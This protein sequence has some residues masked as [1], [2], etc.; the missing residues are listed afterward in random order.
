MNV[1]IAKM[2]VPDPCTAIVPFNHGQSTAAKPKLSHIN[3][4]R[5]KK[6]PCKLWHLRGQNSLVAS[7]EFVC[8]EQNSSQCLERKRRT[9]YTRTEQ[10]CTKFGGL[11]SKYIQLPC[12]SPSLAYFFPVFV[13][14]VFYFLVSLP[15]QRMWAFILEQ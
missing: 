5:W 8:W 15:V 14:F 9:P 10:N 7:G 6:N 1:Y 11:W 2:T 3:I 4:L 12:V 13:T